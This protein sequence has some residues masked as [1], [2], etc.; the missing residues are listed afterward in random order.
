M[1]KKSKIFT[2]AVLPALFIQALGSFLYFVVLQD[3]FWASLVYFLVKSIMILWSVLIVF[4]FFKNDF[5]R[6]PEKKNHK[7]SA[8]LGLLAGLFVVLL[9]VFSYKLFL[10]DILSDNLSAIQFK[11]DQLALG[12]YFIPFAIIL[13]TFNA[14]FE[15]Y[16]WR[17]FAFRGLTMKLA[18]PLAMFISAIGFSLHHFVILSEFFAWPMVFFCGFMVFLGGIIMAWIYRKSN[19]ILGAFIFHFLI[20]ITVMSLVYILL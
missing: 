13:S 1:T 19:S 17:W 18:W 9:A 15:E 5:S 4:L 7:L 3:G 12:A 20:D 14:A 8:V 6:F 11:I 16:Y 10:K 2:F